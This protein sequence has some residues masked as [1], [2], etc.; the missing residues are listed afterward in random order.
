M[1]LYWEG[2]LTMPP[3][4]LGDT[5]LLAEQVAPSRSPL[6]QDDSTYKLPSNPAQLD[7]PVG[8]QMLSDILAE[9]AEE[10][11]SLRPGS[12]VLGASSVAPVEFAHLR[13]RHPARFSTSVWNKPAAP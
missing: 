8:D 12:G 1:A 4:S 11:T 3:S 10:V 5:L 6:H 2:Y 9:A 7:C 13:F